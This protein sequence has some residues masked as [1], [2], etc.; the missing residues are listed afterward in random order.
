[1]SKHLAGSPVC[2]C[3]CVYT[4]VRLLRLTVMS[5][6]RWMVGCKHLVLLIG[7][8]TTKTISWLP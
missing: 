4:Y 5:V 6:G 2:V 3:V 1:M 8:V 7:Q